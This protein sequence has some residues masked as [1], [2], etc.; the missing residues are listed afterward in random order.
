MSMSL[1]QGK[2]SLY[3]LEVK[4]DLNDKWCQFITYSFHYQSQFIY[5]F[6]PYRFTRHFTSRTH[7]FIHQCMQTLKYQKTRQHTTTKARTHAHFH[8][9]HPLTF[10]SHFNLMK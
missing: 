8:A 5:Y 6:P 1:T 10:T 9:E 2:S 4:F 7:S 3:M